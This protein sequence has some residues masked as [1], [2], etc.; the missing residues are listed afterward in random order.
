VNSVCQELLGT[1]EVASICS[2]MIG[3]SAL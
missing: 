3:V 2:M 1:V